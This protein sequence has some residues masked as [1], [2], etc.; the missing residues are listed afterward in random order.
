MIL[1]F[2]LLFSLP[3]INSTIFNLPQ[4][5]RTYEFIHFDDITKVVIPTNFDDYLLVDYELDEDK[6]ILNLKTLSYIFIKRDDVRIKSIKYR[7]F[8]KILI[9][10][11]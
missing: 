11:E 1:F 4:Y 5:R 2:S 8:K 7:N 10:G 3:I 9:N 6:K